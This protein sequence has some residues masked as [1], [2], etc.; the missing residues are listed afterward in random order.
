M[1]EQEYR[2]YGIDLSRY[3]VIPVWYVCN[4]DCSICMLAKVKNRMNT[5]KPARFRSLVRGLIKDGRYDGLILS[6]A[7]I[8]TF[9]YLEQYVKGVASYGWFKKIQIQTNGR[10]LADPEYVKRLVDAGVNEFFIS[11]HGLGPVHDAITRVSG[12]FRETMTG[13][14]NL[15]KYPVN[16]IT[17][18]V[19][20]R[21]NYHAIIPL[22]RLLCEGPI[23]EL[24]MWNYFPMERSDTQDMII[25]MA[26][27]IA[28][29]PE[30]VKILDSAGKQLVLKGFPECISPRG[31]I[32]IDSRF[33]LNLIQDD[34]WSEF[35][36]NG[37]GTCYYRE[38][39]A[40]GRCWALSRAYIEKYG[41][42]HELL[43]PRTGGRQWP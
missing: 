19:L 3:A 21:I 31:P 41:D 29:F 32:F 25:R 23:H 18:M 30:I 42:E 11:V 35:G 26:D 40:A 37:F 4:N 13:I 8:T 6:G 38:Q 2:F 7:E 28:L 34:F 12:S 14:L 16:I 17:N 39:C 20:T 43:S 24:H 36:N 1:I 9:E 33:P 22:L 15:S 5:V 10:R 27:V